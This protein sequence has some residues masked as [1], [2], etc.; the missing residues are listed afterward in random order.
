MD[1][2]AQLTS[3]PAGLFLVGCPQRPRLAGA[4]EDLLEARMR[5]EVW[6]LHLGKEVDTDLIPRAPS[7]PGVKLSTPKGPT[8]IGLYQ[9]GAVRAWAPLLGVLR[10]PTGPVLILTPLEH[11]MP[12][13]VR[14][15]GPSWLPQ[16]RPPWWSEKE[17]QPGPALPAPRAASDVRGFLAAFGGSVARAAFGSCVGCGQS[18]TVLCD[19][20][21]GPETT[22]DAGVCGVCALRLAA[23]RVLCPSCARLGTVAP[24]EAAP[25]PKPAEGK[26]AGKAKGRAAPAAEKPKPVEP[27]EKPA[28]APG[29]QRSLF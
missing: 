26:P 16:L 4:W 10:C 1:L 7:A 21:T 15:V 17:E 9:G 5:G 27:V 12:I 25:A 19:R 2:V 23:D 20:E 11:L 8:R 24:S 22:C 13:V 6:P 14:A 18:A 29:P 28:P 3:P